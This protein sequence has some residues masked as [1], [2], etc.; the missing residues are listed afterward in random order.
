MPICDL[1]SSANQL[2]RTTKIL[3][4]SWDETQSHWDDGARRAFE[5]EFLHSVI[6]NTQLV[7]AAIRQ[8]AEVFANAEKALEDNMMD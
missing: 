7:M 6:P 2:Q 4:E 1:Q 3:K 8:M 5:E